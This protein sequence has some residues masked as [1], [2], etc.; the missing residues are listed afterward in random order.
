M[1]TTKTS[2]ACD[3]CGKSVASVKDLQRFAVESVHR[4][5][6][7]NDVV[8]FDLCDECEARFLAAIEPLVP[9][10]LGSE[11]MEMRREA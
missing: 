3:S 10:E 7:Q 1:R 11:L 6:R 2:Y 4:G 5:K 8:V 9:S